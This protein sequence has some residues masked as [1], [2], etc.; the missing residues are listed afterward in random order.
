MATLSAVSEDVWHASVRVIAPV[1]KVPL[2]TFLRRWCAMCLACRL[3]SPPRV[4]VLTGEESVVW[5]HCSV[6]CVQTPDCQW[7]W[8]VARQRPLSLHNESTWLD[9][10]HAACKSCCIHL[11]CFLSVHVHRVSCSPVDCSCVESEF[12]SPK[13]FSLFCPIIALVDLFVWPRTL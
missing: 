4:K 11:R 2:L 8:H 1:F 10:C 12:T 13:G 6:P 7:L 9:L 3:R 5:Y